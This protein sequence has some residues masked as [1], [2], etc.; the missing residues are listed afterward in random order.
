MLKY[1]FRVVF[2]ILL[3]TFSISAAKTFSSH[4]TDSSIVIDGKDNDWNDSLIYYVEDLDGVAGIVN[5]DSSLFI[6]FRFGDPELLRKI[7]IG[8]AALWWNAEGKKKQDFGIRFPG[9]FKPGSFREMAEQ[10]GNMEQNMDMAAGSVEL[11]TPVFWDK[12]IDKKYS[13]SEIN[14][15]AASAGM[16]NGILCYEFRIPLNKTN[17]YALNVKPGQKFRLCFELGGLENRKELLQQTGADKRPPNMGG[18]GGMGRP[19]GGMGRSG[20]R[21]GGMRPGGGM[22]GERPNLKDMFKSEDI[23][24]NVKLTDNR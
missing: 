1:S 10:R 13:W 8:G 5:D 6:M 2:L 16:V 22:R 11:I 7:M 20:G 18:R 9:T 15:I 21:G 12:K 19:G 24:I 23:W 17:P 3:S 14:G 4:V